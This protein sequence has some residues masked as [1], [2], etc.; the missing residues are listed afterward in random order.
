MDRGRIAKNSFSD[1]KSL[2]LEDG[3]P[4]NVTTRETINQQSIV[5]R[6]ISHSHELNTNKR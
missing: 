4:G 3:Y 1:D 2:Y 5:N 6:N